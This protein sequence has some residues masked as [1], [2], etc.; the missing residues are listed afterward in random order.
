MS[1][2]TTL[3]LYRLIEDADGW[4]VRWLCGSK[5]LCVFGPST[6][7]RARIYLDYISKMPL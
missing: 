1:G 7:S 2:P 3:V 5:W 4:S 6:E